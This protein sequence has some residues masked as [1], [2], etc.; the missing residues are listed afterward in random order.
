[1]NC[2]RCSS[3]QRLEAVEYCG[4]CLCRVV[5]HRVKKALSK[6]MAGFRDSNGNLAAVIACPDPG[7]L[8]CAAAAYLVRRL[9]G[10]SADIRFVSESGL[11][12]ALKNKNKAFITPMCA[13]DLATAFLGLL[14]GNGGRVGKVETSGP[15]QHRQSRCAEAAKPPLNILESVTEKELA[16]YAEMKKIKYREK[17]QSVLKLQIQNLQ[18][19]YPGTVEALARSGRHLLEK[20]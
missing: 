20:D 1:M 3:S 6:N 7:S 17:E 4:S 10:A 14:M 8:Q 13:D 12:K 9:F 16:Y 11:S 19:C 18:A 5:E 2:G 15:I